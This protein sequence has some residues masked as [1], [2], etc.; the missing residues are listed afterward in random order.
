MRI[1]RNAENSTLEMLPPKV[2]VQH[3][4]QPLF[5]RNTALPSCTSSQGEVHRHSASGDSNDGRGSSPH[6][7]AAS[8]V[9][10]VARGLAHGFVR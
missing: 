10:G 3:L 4:L 6:G 5:V 8:H 2:T 1:G 7:F 9:P